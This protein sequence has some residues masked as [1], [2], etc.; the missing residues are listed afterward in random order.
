MAEHA[1]TTPT[2]AL[3]SEPTDEDVAAWIER[4]REL[5]GHFRWINPEDEVVWIGCPVASD[6]ATFSANLSP[7]LRLRIVEAAKA[8]LRANGGFY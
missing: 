7:A 5:G 2:A 8:L 3:H 4:F 1:H 6:A